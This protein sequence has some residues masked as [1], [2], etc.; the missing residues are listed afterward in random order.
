M[1]DRITQPYVHTDE[2]LSFVNYL[3]RAYLVE[4]DLSGRCDS[5]GSY[6]WRCTSE[7]ASPSILLTR[8][9]FSDMN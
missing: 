8:Y 1:D 4:G 3:F 5:S 9:P 6:H 7:I 2:G